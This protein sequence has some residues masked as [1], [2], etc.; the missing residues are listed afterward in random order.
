MDGVGTPGH[1]HHC[2]RDE[3]YV[4]RKRT[5]HRRQCGRRELRKLYPDGGYHFRS[6]ELILALRKSFHHQRGGFGLLHVHEYWHPYFQRQ[7]GPELYRRGERHEDFQKPDA[8]QR[9]R[10][11]ERRH[12]YKR[13]RRSLSFW[14]TC[15]YFVEP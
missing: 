4:C 9:R 7:C 14:S 10:R 11:Y 15:D 12:R 1:R 3:W 5:L 8:A 6:Y 13:E 2:H